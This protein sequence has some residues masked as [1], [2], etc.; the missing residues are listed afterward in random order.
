MR[1]LSQL[2]GCIEVDDFEIVWAPGY[3]SLRAGGNVGVDDGTLFHAGSVAKPVSTAGGL[4]TTPS[5]LARIAIEIMRE[6]R[7]PPIVC[8]PTKWLRRCWRRRSRSRGTLSPMPW[9]SALNARGAAQNS[10][11][12]TPA[13]RGVFHRG[14]AGVPR[15]GSGRGHHDELGHRQPA[16]LR[17][18][19]RRVRGIRLATIIVIVSCRYHRCRILNCC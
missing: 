16:P 5:D 10:P 19:P 13:A 4:W 8:S 6:Y 17:G 18:S 9:L 1:H 7:G 11:S 15:N 3:G 14:S 2:I 12:C